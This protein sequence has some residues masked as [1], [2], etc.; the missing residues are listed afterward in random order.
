[1][2]HFPEANWIDLVRGIVRPE[3]AAVMRQHLDQG[4][5]P[6][7][8]TYRFWQR[9]AGFLQQEPQADPPA[10]SVRVAKSYVSE[11]VVRPASRSVRTAHLVFDTLGQPLAAGVRST[12]AESRH[13]LYEAPPFTIDLHVDAHTEPE[14]LRLDGQVVEEGRTGGWPPEAHVSV[15]T[16]DA[17]LCSVDIDELGEFQCQ[18]ARREDLSLAVTPREGELILISLK[19]NP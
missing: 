11:P 14:Q 18:I 12:S 6:C 19:V 4:C 15:N 8:E 2:P 10:D 1:M 9:L 3:D 16:A 17:Q 7:A 5:A 13:L